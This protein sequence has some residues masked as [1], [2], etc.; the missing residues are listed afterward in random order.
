M[1]IDSKKFAELREASRNG[2]V[3]ASE[4]LKSFRDGGEH[5]SEM[6][7]EYFAPKVEE[8]E[9]K[10][11]PKEEDRKEMSRLEKFLADNDVTPDSPD[12]NEYVE[13]F[14]SM[15]PEEKVEVKE[16]EKPVEEEVELSP[17]AEAFDMQ[18]LIDDETEAIEGYDKK[19]LAITN[20]DMDQ[21]LK[22]GIIAELSQ[23][24][25]EE[26]RHLNSLQELA[27]KLNHKEEQE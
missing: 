12:Y 26:I 7:E 11:E 17:E 4:I 19:I 5:V 9:I 15:F 16:E 6:I 18:K 8:P 21:T 27:N 14:N 23:I 3:K 22:M 24:K 1:Y 10:E 20:L 2:D 13:E 25:N